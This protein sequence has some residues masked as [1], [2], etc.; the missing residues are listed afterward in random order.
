M[1]APLLAVRNL[2]TYFD[3]Y[4]GTVRAVDDVTFHINRGEIFGLVGETG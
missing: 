1:T 2:K 3:T 4:E